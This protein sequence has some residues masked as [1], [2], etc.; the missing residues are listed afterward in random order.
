M[1]ALGLLLTE[2]RSPNEAQRLGLLL[3]A[4]L[5][6]AACLRSEAPAISPPHYTIGVQ[7]GPTGH[8]LVCDLCH[9]LW[10]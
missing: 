10:M 7:K 1:G 9:I 2:G 4:T 5:G 8:F 6:V 3:G